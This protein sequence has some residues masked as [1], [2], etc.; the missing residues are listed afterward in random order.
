MRTL[1]SLLLTALALSLILSIIPAQGEYA[2]MRPGDDCAA[3]R[4][5][6]QAL[7]NWGLDVGVDGRYGANTEAAVRSFQA[8]QGI[9]QDGVAGS[10]T[11]SLLFS[12]ASQPIT[13]VPVTPAQPA[14][15]AQ[16]APE[17]AARQPQISGKLSVGSQGDQVQNLQ[18]KLKDLGY[19]QGRTDGVFDEVTRG[20]VIAF[21]AAQGLTQDG[22]AGRRTLGRLYAAPAPAAGAIPSIP[23]PEKPLA[24]VIS[25]S[26]RA[27]V[28]NS[29]ALR[30]RSEPDSGKNNVVA[31]LK[32]GDRV[33]VSG[34]QG[35]WS[36][37]SW[38][39][40]SGYVMSKYL[41][42]ETPPPAP[43]PVLSDQPAEVPAD[44][45]GQPIPGALQMGQQD[46][47]DG[48]IR[49]MQQRLKDLGYSLAVD[50]SFGPGTHA[51]VVKFQ[52]SNGLSPS[53]VADQN[54][55]SALYA[56][57]AK[58]PETQ[59]GG[60]V[61]LSASKGG[62]P[63]AS[64]VK[65]MD[66]YSEVKPKLRSGQTTKVY[67]PASG[68][69]FD[70]QMYSLGRHADAE[71]KTLKDTQVMNSAFGRASWDTRPVYVKLPTGEWTLATMHNYPH[72]S[73]S[74]KDNGFGGHLCIHFKRDL[75]E[76]QKA[77]PNYG[78]QNQKT[79]RKT[80]QSMTGEVVN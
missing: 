30:M 46:G 2:T 19:H 39:K 55:L 34:Q 54:T 69:S 20:S 48:S 56:A 58:G 50:G 35:E 73:G 33:Q 70:V 71:P 72:L 44:Q 79:I 65:L 9:R 49:A 66:W 12:G 42:L 68:M 64:S 28:I 78:M 57:A 45:S 10:Q 18:Q 22:I 3:V 62:G 11:Q 16:P 52:Q 27:T 59:A 75:E 37:V 23:A 24:P 32:S 6:Q 8:R 43:V 17:T 21:Q 51:Q 41:K 25:V 67:H 36:R 7:R 74:I 29:R 60:S 76:T 1:R 14:D 61:D 40:Y 13:P 15:P 5:L 31:V 4:D 47:A 26:S 63:S 80:W 77:D 38:Y 53:G